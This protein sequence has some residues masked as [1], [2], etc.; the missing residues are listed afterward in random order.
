ML[1]GPTPRRR[2]PAA[3]RGPPRWPAGGVGFRIPIPPSIHHRSEA[4]SQF[5]KHRR[6]L[7]LS[8]FGVSAA[9]A[10]TAADLSAQQEPIPTNNHVL[11]VDSTY[12]DNDL[13]SPKV[14][15]SKIVRIKRVP[16]LQLLFDKTNLPVG[17]KLRITSLQDKV[18]L[19]L[20]GVSLADY[21]NAT[22][23]FNGD[24]VRIELIAAPRTKANRVLVVGAVSG[25]GTAVGSPE[26]ICGNKD[27][28]KQSLDK[29]AGR[30]QVGCSAWLFAR[31]AMATAGHCMGS[32]NQFMEFN[33]PN[34]T[35]SGGIV[36]SHPDDQYRVVSSTVKLLSNGV[37]QDWS[38]AQLAKNANTG[39]LPGDAQGSW[40]SVGTVPTSTIGQNI[41]ITGY[42]S[43]SPRNFL[44]LVQKT[45]VGPMHTIQST[46]VRYRTDTTGGN[47]GSPV[48]HE[49]T[50]KVV[51]VHTHGGCTVSGG[52]NYGTRVDRSDFAAAI[53]A[54][55]GTNPGKIATFG[56][57]C[58]GSRGVP[59]LALTGTPQIGK[60]ITYLA[61]NVPFSAFGLMV[62]GVS[63]TK[64]GATTLP[65]EL[66]SLGMKGC[67]QLVSMD[68]FLPNPSQASGIASLV[69]T[70]PNLTNLIGTT[71]Y[72]E[73]AVA[74]KG[75][76]AGNTTVTNGVALTIGG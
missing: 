22:C 36:R 34:S 68:A 42:G 58:K 63:N 37:G 35:S 25:L 21:G 15:F 64:Q 28:R 66:T 16:W 7:A 17:S 33:V 10:T 30:L 45:H 47:S 38:V 55:L 5:R 71:L 14:V 9:T 50:G 32:M 70:I 46:Y 18:A 62:F 11:S 44:Y 24:A 67:F 41:R 3:N 43:T 53:Q 73:Y 56:A 51:G 20:D 48:I 6:V 4:I 72:T 57:G 2:L 29:R 12:L 52:A 13:G 75:A 23:Y 27:D 49:N 60:S 65:F 26:T 40:Y 8:L 69:G 31:D 76:N 54:L 61:S 1:R 19:T 39:K 59:A 74:D